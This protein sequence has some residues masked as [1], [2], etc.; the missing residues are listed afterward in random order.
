MSHNTQA[1][2]HDF[3]T[4]LSKWEKRD[5]AKQASVQGPVQDTTVDVKYMF[6]GEHKNGTAC[7]FKGKQWTNFCFE[8]DIEDGSWM[9]FKFQGS[10]ERHTFVYSMQPFNSMGISVH[11]EPPHHC[12]VKRHHHDNSRPY[13]FK[14]FQFHTL[15]TNMLV[16]NNLSTTINNKLLLHV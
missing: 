8:N 1:L 9:L 4:L 12:S 16:N 13:Y 6:T 7:G 3:L 2:P 10:T 5:Q 15:T 14:K 11:S